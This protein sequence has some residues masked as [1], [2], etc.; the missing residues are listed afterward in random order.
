MEHDPRRQDTRHDLFEQ[1]VPTRDGMRVARWIAA[2]RD[3]F[4]WTDDPTRQGQQKRRLYLLCSGRPAGHAVAVEARWICACGDNGQWRTNQIDVSSDAET[5][6][7]R[8]ALA[9]AQPTPGPQTRGAT[10]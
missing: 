9:T 8:H 2:A 4:D 10:P 1:L 6:A 5:H 7:L 3:T